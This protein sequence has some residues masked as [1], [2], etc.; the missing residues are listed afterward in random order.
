MYTM[1]GGDGREYGP[2]T[3]EQLRQWIAEGRI[4][5]NTQLRAE[6][7]TEWKPI[8]HFPEFAAAFAPT[9]PG[10]PPIAPI[11][12]QPYREPPKTSGMAIASLVLGVCGFFCSIFTSIPGLI[13]GFIGL[14]KINKS[15]GQVTG[16]GLAIAGICLSV[17][18]TV[19]TV[20]A[21]TVWV[22]AVKK[23]VEEVAKNLEGVA[24]DE[25][26]VQ[27]CLGEQAAVE[28]AK[29]LNE[30]GDVVVLDYNWGNQLGKFKNIVPQ[31]HLEG[32][33]R[34]L[35]A[36]SGV[37]LLAV[38]S[39]DP[40]AMVAFTTNAP[41]QNLLQIAGEYPDA[42][43]IVS[44]LGLPAGRNQPTQGDFSKLPKVVV[45]NFTLWGRGT[46]LVQNGVVSAAITMRED[47]RYD[48]TSKD[49]PC[50]QLF[51]ARYQV[52]TKENVDQLAAKRKAKFP[53]AE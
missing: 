27:Q 52:V 37:K 41:E 47:Y 48:R 1:I 19:A 13:L 38:K 10:A 32:F 20:V 9:M 18:S 4:A 42:E 43:A 23:G 30:Q 26:I 12:S 21:I 36:H 15:D 29:L 51:E 35:T 44:F 5:A 34:G 16:K 11:H 17:A 39:F 8:S 24:K 28:T 45:V 14:N 49:L 33:K 31:G 40:Q 22:L 7:Q 53:T 6:G 25:S 46:E 2:V 3:T 50:P